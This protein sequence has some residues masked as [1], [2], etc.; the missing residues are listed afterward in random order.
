MRILD[1]I[2]LSAELLVAAVLVL[3]STPLVPPSSYHAPIESMAIFPALAGV[4]VIS[5][6]V[7]LPHRRALSEVERAGIALNLG[8]TAVLLVNHFWVWGFVPAIVLW[9]F[10]L[11]VG[12]SV[13]LAGILNNVERR[14][15]AQWARDREELTSWG[16]P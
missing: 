14:R 16:A 2:L 5:Y 12:V 9:G 8:L 4:F 10:T 6:L 3:L 11:T 1:R 15:Q 13:I 7:A